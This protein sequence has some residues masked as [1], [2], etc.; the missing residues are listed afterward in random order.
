LFDVSDVLNPKEVAKIEIGDKGT[1]SDALYDHKAVL[2]DKE[3]NLLV[4]PVNLY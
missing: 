1:S 2:F 4:L 3:K